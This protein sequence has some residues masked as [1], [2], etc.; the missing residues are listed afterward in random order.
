MPIEWEKPQI[1]EPTKLSVKEWEL[2]FWPES[3]P[4]RAIEKQYGTNGTFDS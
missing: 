2:L 1:P 4:N 3:P